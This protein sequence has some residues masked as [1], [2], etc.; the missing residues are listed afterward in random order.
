MAGKREYGTIAV[1]W[2]GMERARWP[3]EGWDR[4]DLALV[5]RLARLRL[6]LG[7][8]GAR[9]AVLDADP[10]LAALL[11]LVGLAEV[12]GADDLGAC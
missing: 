3:L 5:E 8:L 12:L 1:S 9:I 10:D 4:A 2:A 6:V 11:E 7:R